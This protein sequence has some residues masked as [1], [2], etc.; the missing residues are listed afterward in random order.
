M[1]SNGLEP[2][3]A[4]RII[5]VRCECMIAHWQAFIKRHNLIGQELSIPIEE[6]LSGVGAEIEIL[7]ENAARIEQTESYPGIAVAKAGFVPVGGC[8]IGSGDPYFINSNDPEGGPLY[9]IYHDEVTDDT[10]DASRAVAIVLKDYRELLKYVNTEPDAPPNSGHA[11]Q[12]GDSKI[13]E[14]RRR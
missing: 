8:N 12:L 4:R 6:D 14:G 3:T 11:T 5:R 2:Q 10:Y 13:S 7:D 9:R 1:E